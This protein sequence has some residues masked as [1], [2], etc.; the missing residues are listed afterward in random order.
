MSGMRRQVRS[1][2]NRQASRGSSPSLI[3]FFFW[4]FF[5]VSTAIAYL[6]VYNQTGV[7]ATTLIEKKELVQELESECTDLQL[8]IDELSQIDRITRI[9]RTELGM[10][11]PQAESL[12]VYVS[13]DEL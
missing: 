9:A 6:W 7:A 10:V 1:P 3:T 13:V 4:T 11:I 8:K 12:I 2:A 5:L